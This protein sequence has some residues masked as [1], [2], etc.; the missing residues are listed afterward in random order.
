MW[1]LTRKW[2]EGED[3]VNQSPGS[4]QYSDGDFIRARTLRPRSGPLRYAVNKMREMEAREGK[5]Q[6]G[7]R[8]DQV[9]DQILDAPVSGRASATGLVIL[10]VGLAP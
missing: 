1:C 7:Y 2:Q 4:V 10:A 3:E 6:I 8:A 5:P 9:A